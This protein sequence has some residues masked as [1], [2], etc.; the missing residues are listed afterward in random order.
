MNE[1]QRF[2]GRL[3]T[4]AVLASLF[5]DVVHTQNLIRAS[6]HLEQGKGSVLVYTNH[7]HRL[8]A[9]ITAKVI[10]EYLAKINKHLSI[11]VSKQYTDENREENKDIVAVMHL[12]QEIYGFNMLSAVQDKEN[13]RTTYPDWLTIN[14]GVVN[15]LATFLQESGNIGGITLEGTRSTTGALIEAKR[16]FELLLKKGGS[17]LLFQPMALVHTDIQPL[18]RTRVMIPEPFTRAEILAEHKANPHLSITDLAMLKIARELPPENRGYYAQMAAEF[19]IP[20][21]VNL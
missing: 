7:F 15:D 9:A 17:N 20:Q 14:M 12:L 18:T 6:E 16:G 8:D 19:V 11:V 13:E 5:I 2:F 10:R 21:K 1:G 3:A 4:E